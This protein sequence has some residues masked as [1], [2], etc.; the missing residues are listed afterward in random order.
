M[1]IRGVCVCLAL[2]LQKQPLQC[3]E[4]SPSQRVE[5]LVS[6]VAIDIR[7]RQKQG[8]SPDQSPPVYHVLIQLNVL[9]LSSKT[10]ILV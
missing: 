9:S 7:L 3:F 2:L 4:E 10:V 5:A 6:F 1:Q 8:L